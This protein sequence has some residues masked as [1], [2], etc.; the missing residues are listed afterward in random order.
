MPPQEIDSVPNKSDD[1]KASMPALVSDKPDLISDK[2][3]KEIKKK[4]REILRL[5]KK[6]NK[7]TK[8]NQQS[9]KVQQTLFKISELAS[10]VENLEQF[11]RSLHKTIS[12]LLYADNF[13]IALVNDSHTALDLSYFVDSQ[14]LNISQEDTPYCIALSDKTLSVYLY[15]QQ[16]TILLTTDDI[17]KLE[18]DGKITR[19]GPSAHSW[20]GAP[21]IGDS[22]ILG[23]IVVQSYNQ[24]FSFENWHKDLF[25]YVS[26]AI[27]STLERKQHR[28][29]LE[30]KVKLRTEKLQN[31]IDLRRHHQKIESVLLRISELA[32]SPITLSDFY[33]KLHAIISELI[34]AK[35]FYIALADSKF[36]RFVYYIDSKDDIT[37]EG[38]A[39]LPVENAQNSMTAYLIRNKKSFLSNNQEIE[40]LAKKGAINLQGPK[41]QSWLGIPLIMDGNIIGVMVLQ[42]YI[43]EQRFTEQD[44]SLMEYISKPVATAIQR[45]TS[46]QQ[47]ELLVDERTVDLDKINREL[48]IQIEEKTKAEKLQRALYDIANLA[49]GAEDMRTF[50]QSIHKILSKLFYAG[51][52]YIALADD[53]DTL[54]FEYI[55][56]LKDQELYQEK[57]I[58]TNQGS[59][60][61]FL[62]H[63][64]KPILL[65]WSD[66]LKLIKEKSIKLSGSPFVS[67]LGVPLKEKNHSIGIMVL[68]SYLKEFIYDT[69]HLELLEYVSQ[70]VATTLHRKKAKDNL[71]KLIRERTN[72]LEKEIEQHKK[73]Q[74][75][76]LALYQIANL[77]SKDLELDEFY[78]ELH[79]IIGLLICSENFYIALKG[80]TNNTI[81]MV[82]Y[83]DT[84]D[85]F[86]I[87]SIASFPMESLKK[88]ITAYVMKTGTPLLINKQEM[89]ALTKKENLY[90]H[91]EQTVSWLGVPLSI[92]GNT[93][94]VMT[95]QSYI[96]GKHLTTKD[97][98]LMIFV[99]QHVASALVRKKN[100]DYLTLLVE[101]RT[102]ELTISNQRLQNEIFQR[103]NSEKLQ[104]ALFKISETPQE[105][106]NEKELYAR[107]HEIISQLMQAES[108]YIARV[109]EKQDC[110]IFD[111]VIDEVDKNIP[112]SIPIGKS[113][114]GYV[115][116]QRKIIHINRQKIKQLEERGEI[117]NWG[118]YAIDWVGVPLL[119]GTSVL[120]I[121]ILQSYDENY[122]YG[123]RE[124]EIL[125]FVSTHIADALERTGAKKKLKIAYKE[126]AEKTRN[127]EAASEAKSSFLATVSHEIRTPMNGILGMLSLISDTKMTKKQHDYV[128][129]ISISSNSLLGIIDDILDYSKIEK[130]KLELENINFEILDLLDN[131]VDIFSGNIIE[132]NLTFNIDLE[133]DVTLSRVGDSLR[134]TQVLINLIGNAIKFTEKG[135]IRLTVKAPSKNKLLFFVEDSGIGIPINKRDKIFNSFTQADDTTTRKFGG[136]G[137]GLS[138]CQQLVS[139]MNGWIKVSGDHGSGS[140]FSFEIEMQEAQERYS[141]DV[142][143]SANKLLL[144]SEDKQQK[145]CWQ[146][147]C[148]KFQLPLLA[149]TLEQFT[150]YRQNQKMPTEYLSHIFI[151]D[152]IQK[153]DGLSA[154]KKLRKLVAAKPLFFLLCQS[155][156]QRLLQTGSDENIQIISKPIKMMSLLNLMSQQNRPPPPLGSKKPKDNKIR[157]KMLGRKILLAEDNLINQQVAKEILRQSGA[158]VTVVDNG[159]MATEACNVYNFDLV[160]MDMQM[161]IMD[162][163]Q[164]SKQIR[165]QYSITEL[166]IIAM[167]ANVMK[168]DKEKCIRYGM[169]DYISKPINRATFFHTIEQYL[170]EPKIIS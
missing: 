134:L 77:A 117:E 59:L 24:A 41:C 34:Y 12:E 87:Q 153:H 4:D 74:E 27:A 157:E 52:F 160:L 164:A 141:K 28:L 151:D 146:H 11:Y 125:N 105:C 54:N 37:V 107:L 143:Y 85:D 78:K 170:I 33:T 76:Q 123:E 163:Y 168:G 53:P 67:W 142:K 102:R 25:D 108:F 5:T 100:K 88:S 55:S 116:Q 63:S 31:E 130:G 43:N 162:G 7:Q 140:C 120:G 148:L 144:I 90:I 89:A 94:G 20:L 26:Y 150:E 70:Q 42:S 60:S 57:S 138:I 81:E 66:Y 155:P 131:L 65:N 16:K 154:L 104:T 64:D 49:S 149:M 129:K 14:H 10:G 91:G 103:K 68:Q 62:Y 17:E 165:E 75:T 132:K 6:I 101:K 156:P 36:I 69:W 51:N 3:A 115:Y 152:D 80:S 18:A 22:R 35:N 119:S 111:Y 61:A 137:L 97:K 114:T 46:Q 133:P 122:I 96:T 48:T 13:Y 56:V 73:S 99:G 98:E 169:N 106:T 145:Q 161:P 83:V 39:A 72:N 45:K 38:L 47:L 124:I 121:L 113:L 29:A 84:M 139:M 8:Q 32:N 128:S 30:Q 23:V 167:T 19:F 147:F 159:L 40:A 82:Y 1:C 86:N 135:F 50:Y 93:I 110:F 92:D 95:I 58:S 2:S 109:N 126:L 127:A 15:E 71:E 166:P 136:S 118:S 112:E 79:K 44:K 21:L 158:V 9:L